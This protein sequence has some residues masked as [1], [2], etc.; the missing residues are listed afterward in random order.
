M[1]D[2]SH[3]LVTGGAGFIGSHLVDLLLERD[4]QV[5]VLDKLT[6]AGTRE[7]LR[8]HDDDGR[9]RLAERRAVYRNGPARPEQPVR[10]EQGRRRSPVSLVPRDVRTSGDSGPGHERI[11]PASASREGHPRVHARR[12]GTTPGPRVRGRHE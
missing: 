2:P 3:V 9:V 1:T 12:A 4:A 10:R 8:R 5:T 11:W 6:Y 7:N